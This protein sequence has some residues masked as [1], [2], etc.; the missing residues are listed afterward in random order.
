MK[1]IIL[2]LLI[3][4]LTVTSGLNLVSAENETNITLAEGEEERLKIK[5]DDT[6][7]ASE[8]GH[9]NI[10]FDDG[11][12]G[13]CIN[14]GQEEA[15]EGD[16]YKVQDTS[17]AINNMN[18]ESV[19]NELKTFFV[20]Y[21]D[22]AM[23]DKIKTQHII[24]H[25]SDGFNGWRVDPNLMEEIRNTASSKIIP[26]HGATRKINDTSEM[27]FDFEVLS[28]GKAGHQNYFAYKITIRD[29]IE[30]IINGNSTENLE[31]STAQDKENSTMMNST[32]QNN[33]SV[34]PSKNENTSNTTNDLKNENDR[35]DNVNND[36]TTSAKINETNENQYNVDLKK[37]KTGYEYIPAFLILFFGTLILIKKFRD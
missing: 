16:D 1:K 17:Y 23:K 28:S 37:H 3:T 19:G 30:D 36:E 9:F 12:N 26:D 15:R 29:I 5:N 2:T 35:K 34:V 21:Y 6:V 8:D 11:Y 18:G 25:F 10:S 32:T 13:Y 14:Y 22:I 33:T 4:F 31:N 20:D 27:I 24:W 7:S